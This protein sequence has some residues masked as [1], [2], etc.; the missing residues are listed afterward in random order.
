M[1]GQG[2]AGSKKEK[3]IFRKEIRNLGK[4]RSYVIGGAA[5]D[6]LGYDVIPVKYKKNLELHDLISE[7]AEDLF[8]DCQAMK[9]R[10]QKNQHMIKKI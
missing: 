1:E 2:G 9:L 4:F 3:R 7:I 8:N 5:C 10:K 6:T